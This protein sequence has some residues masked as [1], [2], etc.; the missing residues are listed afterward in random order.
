MVKAMKEFWRDEEGLGTLEI[1]L[2][3]VVLV[4]VALMFKD[5][6]TDWVRSI[7]TELDGKMGEGTKVPTFTENPGE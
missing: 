4:G 1:L 2:I 7:L 3:V 6:I 5:R